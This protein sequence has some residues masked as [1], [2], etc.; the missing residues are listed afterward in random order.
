M[1]NLPKSTEVRKIIT[2][3]L[4]YEKFAAEL[5]GEKKRVFDEDISKIVIIN[6]ISPVSVNIKEGEQVKSIF[7]VQVELKNKNYNERNLVMISKL[8]G[9]NLLMALKY[10]EDYQFA[11]FQTKLLHSEW[12]KE[13]ECEL[14][15][16][17]LDL[18]AVWENLVSQVSGIVVQAGNTLN[19]QISYES[20]KAKLRKQIDDLEKKARKETQS[21]KKFE[22]HQRIKAYVKKLEEMQK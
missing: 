6:E 17:G 9:Q 16:N 11:I 19:E 2:K 12:N 10:Q 4:I 21:K 20:E 7:L 5:N 18:D 22:M 8:F 13:D 3:K 14:N 15:L 1:F